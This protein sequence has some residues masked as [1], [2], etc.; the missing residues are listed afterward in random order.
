MH[1]LHL[2]DGPDHVLIRHL[3]VLRS[4]ASLS[5]FDKEFQILGPRLLNVSVPYLFDF[6]VNTVSLLGLEPPLV[7][8]V[9]ISFI[10]I[11]FKSLIV[12]KTSVA[13][14][15]SFLISSVGLL[16]NTRRCSYEDL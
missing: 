10:N 7:F 6:C 16:A 5:S 8:M 11:G 2:H 1:V 9:K 13:N 4:F 12:L 15:L 3:K 14:N